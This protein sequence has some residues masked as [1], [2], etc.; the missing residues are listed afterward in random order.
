[1]ES[2]IV[3]SLAEFALTI[4]TIFVFINLAKLFVGLG[5]MAITTCFHVGTEG[6]EPPSR[7]R[8]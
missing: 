6:F 3:L 1:M 7:L 2:V 8:T 5:N 4:V